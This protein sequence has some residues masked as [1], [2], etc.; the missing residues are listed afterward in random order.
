M[1][2]QLWWFVAIGSTAVGTGGG[3]VTS[4]FTIKCLRR[5]LWAG[6]IALGFLSLILLLL[7]LPGLLFLV[8]KGF[9]A[10]FRATGVLELGSAP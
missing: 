3:I 10:F 6:A 8:D 2:E 5:R 4:V 7:G 1:S 9:A